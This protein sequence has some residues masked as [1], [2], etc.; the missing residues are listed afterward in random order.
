MDTNAWNT[1]SR[2]ID[3]TRADERVKQQAVF[4]LI[5]SLKNSDYIRFQS[6]LDAGISP[7][8]S[9]LLRGDASPPM[10]LELMEDKYLEHYPYDFIT[11]LGW[12]ALHDDV[13][14]SRR[15]V[16]A[17]AD[18]AFPGP[19]GRDAL[20]MA[21][22]GASIHTWDFLRNEYT[23]LGVDVPYSARTTDGKR[24]TR[25]MDAVVR[26]NV[27]AVADMIKYV[28]LD[29]VDYTGRTALHYN[30]LQDPYNEIDSQIGKMLIQY[31][32]PVQGED[33][34]GVSPAS[35]AQTPEQTI[36]INRSILA[37]VTMEAHERAQA[38]RNQIEA[39]KPGPDMDPSEP[40]F[41]QIQKPVRFKTPKM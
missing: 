39:N 20:W 3:A 29:A 30:F 19:Q 28:P 36:L 23:R 2:T 24:T 8:A 40:A 25:L 15:L 18:I 9:M 34:E 26:R 22:L 11:P 12:A 31:G 41:P 13:E 14:S 16:G 27:T 35:L 6:L 4:R 17:G 1:I 38:Q 32:A 7:D 37:E 5:E 10:A 21:L 33:H